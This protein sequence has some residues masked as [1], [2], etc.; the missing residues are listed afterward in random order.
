MQ[1][2]ITKYFPAADKPAKVVAKSSGGSKVSLSIPVIIEDV[3][4][5][6]VISLCKKLHWTGKLHRGT[7]NGN[8]DQVWVFDDFECVEIPS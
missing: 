4:K 5:Y 2:I 1:V 6:A 8:G 7:L 3:H